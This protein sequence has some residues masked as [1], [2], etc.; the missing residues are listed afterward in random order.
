MD[1]SAVGFMKNLNAELYANEYARL[2]RY[3]EETQTYYY[4]LWNSH[5]LEKIRT[6]IK[7]GTVIPAGSHN[8]YPLGDN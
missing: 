1:L 8:F 6:Q 4:D 5:E 2:G 7:Q 3:M